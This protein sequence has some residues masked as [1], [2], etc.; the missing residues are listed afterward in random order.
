M[1]PKNRWLLV[2]I[3]VLV[4]VS[5]TRDLYRSW[6]QSR[7]H[8]QQSS[9]EATFIPFLEQLPYVA[10]DQSSFAAAA[11]PRGYFDIIPR[12]GITQVELSAIMLDSSQRLIKKVLMIGGDFPE[13]TEF[14]IGDP[15]QNFFKPA[16]IIEQVVVPPI[17]SGPSHYLFALPSATRWQAQR[18][19]TVELE[20]FVTIGNLAIRRKGAEP[21]NWV[22]GEFFR[23]NEPINPEHTYTEATTDSETI[24]V[25]LVVKAC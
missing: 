11:I 5:L 21:E 24:E 20:N 19:V 23:S 4:L 12:D 15:V 2:C 22:R 17:Q 3:V 1:N 6:K 16:R 18:I 7:C 14:E 9:V 8:P 13:N 10:D 25:P